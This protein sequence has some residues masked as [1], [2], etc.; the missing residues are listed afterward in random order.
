MA[1]TAEEVR[2]ARPER[3]P[4]HNLE[5]EESVLGS[6]MLSG[7]AIAS[8]VEAMKP[9]D[10]YRPAH[11]RI[12][13]AILG[14]YGRGEPVDAI[15]TVEELKRSHALDEVGGPLYLYNLV[16][17]VPTPASAAY[18]ARIVADNALLRRLIEAASQI[19]SR[20]YAV[21][22]DP[23]R[24]ADEAEGLIYAVARQ[25]EK[26]QVVTL[27][28]LVDDSMAALEHIQQRESAFAG[29]PTGFVDV[30]TLLSGLQRGNLIVIAARPGVGK[31]SFVTNI[32]RNVAVDA[33]APVAMFSLEM[34]RFEIGMR[35]LCGE[36]RVPWDKV[37]SGRMATEEWTRIVE[38]AEDLHESPLY[39]V[40]SGNVTIVDIRAKAR[41]MKSKHGL[42]LIIVD[43]L[44]LMSGHHRTENRQ[45]EVAEISRSL[46]LLAKEL[47]VPVIAV[48]QLNR[49]PESRGDKRPQLSDLRECVTGETLVSLAD[50]RRV[51]IREL[52]GTTPRVLAMSAEGRIVQA[53][54]DKVWSVGHRPVFRV[55]LAS[56]RVIR[57]TG[58][59]RLY[60]LDGWIR[61]DELEEGDRLAIARHMPQ[62]DHT[63]EWSEARVSLLAHLIGDERY[64]SNG[65][66][67][68]TTGSNENSRL[69]RRATVTEFGAK[70]TRYEGRGNWHQLLISGNGNRWH[71]AGVN[72]WLRELGAFGQRSHEK[73]VPYEVFRLSNKQIAIFLRHLWATDGCI[74]VRR[75]GTRGSHRVFLGTCS[76]GLADDV[77]ALL[78]RIGIVARIRPVP[79]INRPLFEVCDSGAPNQIRFLEVVGSFGPRRLPSQRLKEALVGV[80]PNTNVDALPLEVFTFVRASMTRRGISE[81]EM[82]A[83]RGTSYGGTSLFAFS[84]S[85]A[86]LASYAKILGDEN[87]RSHATN[88][89]FWDRVIEVVEDGEEEVFDLTV[90]GPA[91]WLADAIINHNSG[92]I[93]QDSDIVMF[94]HRE[95]SDDPTVKGKADLIVAKHRNG[96]TAN[97]PLTFLPHLTLFRNFART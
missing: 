81:R 3:L 4:P 82:A 9:D 73:R 89:L 38:A 66:M 29:V 41:R 24:A 21:P 74:F 25:D 2:R 34:S 70:V 67:R 72:A 94:I 63:I 92:A 18:Y 77:A 47:E 31:S 37:R 68:Y 27:R 84:P 59:H 61:V 52:V 54:S 6:M 64:L 71:P 65:P 44:Q 86:T 43:Y 19:M 12:Y 10:F 39:I 96:P 26:D 17:T 36:A 42:G 46:K 5:A 28:E 11:Q 56:G 95:D 50:G 97:I 75:Q 30:D 49:N 14:I 1:R 33:G 48:S 7:E 53:T 32:A 88:D 35:L 57:A 8:V 62:P 87:L 79:Q 15:T 91:S 83:F 80:A 20:A 45:Q 60:G 51:P 69:D 40:D 55:R 58:R 85:R 23:R 13:Q 78:L 76:R 93:E 90:P 22:D 16:E